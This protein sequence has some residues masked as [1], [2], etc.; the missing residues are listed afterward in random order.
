MAI[1]D[2]FI[3]IGETYTEYLVSFAYL[4]ERM[5]SIGFEPLNADELSVLGLSHSSEMFADTHKSL[6]MYLMPPKVQMFSFLNRWFIFKRRSM[7]GMNSLSIPAAT[8]AALTATESPDSPESD[9]HI[10][11]ILEEEDENIEKEELR[12]PEQ[13]Q[14]QEQETETEIETPQVGG[15]IADG[16][17]YVFNNRSAASKASEMKI[18]KSYGINNKHWRRYLSTYTPFIFHDLYEPSIKYPSLEAAL[19]AAKY[20]IATNKPE[21]GAQL[22]STFGNIHQQLLAQLR[23]LGDDVTSEDIADLYDIEGNMM[24]DSGKSAAIKKTGAKF[25]KFAWDAVKER[26]L[27]DYVRQRFENDTN[28]R[29]ILIGMQEQRALLVYTAAANELSGSVNIDGHIN[30]ENLYGRSLMRMIG[31]MY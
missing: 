18:L 30:G 6:K 3:S 29:N 17:I 22:F 7:A 21:L 11:L 19:S 13:E 8:V 16:P 2:N 9:S 27:I 10:E 1:D 26:I 31:L 12:T 14:E 24:R 28:F 15:S 4:V 23:K 25:D 5:K 20:Q